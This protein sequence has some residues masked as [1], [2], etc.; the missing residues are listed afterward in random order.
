MLDYRRNRL[1]YGEMLV[2]PSGYRLERAVGATYSADLNTLLSIPVALIYAQTLEGKLDTE[3]FQLL[4]AI[5][6]I[7]SKVTVYHQKG[8]LHVPPKYNRLYAFLEDMLVPVYPETAFSSFHPKL[9]VLR[10]VHEE[11]KYEPIHR[12]IVLSRN[13]T[14][15]RSWDVAMCLEGVETSDAVD[16][17]QPLC[18]FLKYLNGLSPFPDA[19]AFIKRIS[20]TKF[21]KPDGFGRL[22]F[23]PVGIPGH[24]TS[25]IQTLTAESALIISPFVDNKAVQGIN[26]NVEGDV[27][28]FSRVDELAKLDADVIGQCAQC[29]HLSNWI[30]EGERQLEANGENIED[31]QEQDLH[32]KVYVFEVGGRPHWYLGS[33]N[34]TSAALSRNIEFLVGLKGKTK[35]HI[36][37]LL[38]DLLGED[39]KM[40]VFDPFDPSLAS[41]EDVA[42]SNRAVMRQLEYTLLAAPIKASLTQSENETNYDMHVEVDLASIRADSAMQ[43]YF[44]PLTLNAD[45][46]VLKPGEISKFT[47]DNI[48]ETELSRF[49]VYELCK[50]EETRRFLLRIDVDGMPVSRH[51]CIFKSIVNSREKFFQYLSFLL[52]D[53]REKEDIVAEADDE[54]SAKNK[55]SD[56]EWHPEVPV[57]EQLL[58]AASRDP[59]KL[60]QIDELLS[61]LRDESRDGDVIVPQAFMDF[62]E[63]FRPLIPQGKRSL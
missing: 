8:Q 49:V 48:Q 10:Y 42:A 26:D 36:N 41:G 17:T 9:W 7:A 3:R 38:D 29:Y 34:A 21:D 23:H 32:A 56:G 39:K 33:A 35:G 43:I 22:S 12:T 52:A 53:D 60:K 5:K 18:D 1:D 63:A 4:E 59:R 57:F 61:R 40:G 62:W 15:D 14:F 19:T 37:P 27:Y 58:V 6:G 46:A 31:I 16:Q 20:R 30:V 25:P 55:T 11:D 13:L 51:D 47:F 44:R 50:G 28:L 54:K 2:P 45:P 24:Y